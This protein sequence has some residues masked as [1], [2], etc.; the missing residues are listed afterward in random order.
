MSKFYSEEQI[1]NAVWS[2]LQETR[3]NHIV[4]QFIQEV[5]DSLVPVTELN[6]WFYVSDGNP[7]CDDWEKFLCVD[8]ADRYAVGTYHPKYGWV[9]AHY[10]ND[11]KAWMPL[12]T[13]TKREDT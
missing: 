13:L 10:M 4:V 8:I 1:I 12:P 2:R 7:V 11:I 3:E 9:F 6:D 5:L